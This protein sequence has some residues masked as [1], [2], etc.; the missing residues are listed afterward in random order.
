MNLSHDSAR[1]SDATATS[2]SADFINAISEF[3]ETD[4]SDLLLELGY[5]KR[6]DDAAGPTE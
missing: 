5:Y 4:P 1:D 6:P 3:F 2:P